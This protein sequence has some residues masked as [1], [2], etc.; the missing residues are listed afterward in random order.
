MIDA[1]IRQR[2]FPA[3]FNNG[4]FAAG[5]DARQFYAGNQTI[6]IHGTLPDKFYLSDGSFNSGLKECRRLSEYS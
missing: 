1:L 3:A 2:V 6:D 4:T 5:S